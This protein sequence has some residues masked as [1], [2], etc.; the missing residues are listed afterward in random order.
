MTVNIMVEGNQ[1]VRGKIPGPSANCW[2]NDIRLE[3]HKSFAVLRK[4]CYLSSFLFVTYSVFPLWR[5][6]LDAAVECPASIK[7]CNTSHFRPMP[8]SILNSNIRPF[9]PPILDGTKTANINVCYFKA[10]TYIRLLLSP[11][12]EGM[13][14]RTYLY[15][16]LSQSEAVIY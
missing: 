13:H 6:T 7:W 4:T 16:T 1:A 10:E 3:R 2:Q 11:I 9:F 5:R 12:Y 14:E 8:V 15:V